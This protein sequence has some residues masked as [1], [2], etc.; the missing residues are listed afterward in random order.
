MTEGD[1]LTLNASL[2]PADSK[3]AITYTSSNT[4][5]ATVSSSGKVTAENA[6]KTYIIVKAASGVSTIVAIKVNKKSSSGTV[7]VTLNALFANGLTEKSEPV[8]MNGDGQYTLTFDLG[9]DLSDDGVKA[10]IT[11]LEDLTAIYIRDS[12]IC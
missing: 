3:D 7:N 11:K 1:T 10:G 2:T 12:R 4:S 8:T 6:G 5:I 9:K